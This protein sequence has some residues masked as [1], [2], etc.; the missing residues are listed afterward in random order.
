MPK[1]KFFNLPLNLFHLI[2][3][4]IVYLV[5][6]IKFTFYKYIFV[7]MGIFN[8]FDS[9]KILLIFLLNIILY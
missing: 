5:I 1:N 7:F 4:L 8:N 3:N 6:L 2:L 9:I